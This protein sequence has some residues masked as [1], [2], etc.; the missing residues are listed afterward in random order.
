MVSTASANYEEGLKGIGIVGEISTIAP[1]LQFHKM[2]PSH[3]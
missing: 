2:L 1:T 3:I